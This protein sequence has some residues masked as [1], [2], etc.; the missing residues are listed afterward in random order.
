HQAEQIPAVTRLPDDLETR[1]LQQAGQ[2]FPKQHVVLGD[3][4]PRRR[5]SIACIHRCAVR[6]ALSIFPG[7]TGASDTRG[8]TILHRSPRPHARSAG[9]GA[10]AWMRRW[11][12]S[13]AWVVAAFT[14]A[15]DTLRGHRP[16]ARFKPHTA[17]FRR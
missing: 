6:L 5:L 8:L 16:H 9:F 3:D 17:P 12:G 2:A 7:V 15:G 13:I 11:R 1:P 14:K 10:N 4:D